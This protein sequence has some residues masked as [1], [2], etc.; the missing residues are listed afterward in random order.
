M[1]INIS[2]FMT[3]KFELFDI[4][5]VQ[6]D[7]GGGKTSK[8]EIDMIQKYPNAKSLVISGLDQENFE[9]LI[10]RF[11]SQFEAIS[12]WKNK[13][14]NDLSPLAGLSG[15][16]Y[17]HYF[18]NQRAEELW[19]MTGN[20][21][22]KGLE[23]SDF[24]RVHSIEEITTA[25]SLEYFSIG[26]AVWAKMTINS[27]KPLIRSSV[28]HFAWDG[29]KVLDDDYMCLAKSN[30]KELDMSICRFKMDELARLIASIPDL[31]GAITQPYKVGSIV[32]ED[33]EETYYYLCKGK[34]SLKKGKDDEK[35]EKY[36]ADFA[37]LVEKYRAEK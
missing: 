6:K 25:P 18:W 34:R 31:K 15:I 29:Y 9:Y 37:C 36:L 5:I 27:L 4:S 16:K 28:T 13:L 35:L 12:F 1:K 10:D 11:G 21:N 2:N 30:I 14:V 33:K 22:L 24:T 32:W 8:E 7:V 19:D 17:I 20:T 26:N 3:S 23:I